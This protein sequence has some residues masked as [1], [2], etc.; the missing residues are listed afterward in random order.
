MNDRFRLLAE[1]TVNQLLSAGYCVSH[2]DNIF[3]VDRAVDVLGMHSFVDSWKTEDYVFFLQT[4]E[5]VA[6]KLRD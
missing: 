2:E 5:Q 6:D 1:E 4:V 3:A